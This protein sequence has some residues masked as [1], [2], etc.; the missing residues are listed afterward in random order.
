[1]KEKGYKPYTPTPEERSLW[2]TNTAP[3][4]ESLMK[5]VPGGLELL[6]KVKA[7]MKKG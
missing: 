6:K 5:D 2:E 3:I 7:L 1:M 4:G